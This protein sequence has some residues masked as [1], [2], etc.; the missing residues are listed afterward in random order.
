MATMAF[1]MIVSEFLLAQD[2]LTGGGA[3]IAVP[4]FNPPFDTPNGLFWLV[5]LIATVVTWLTWNVS[6]LMWGRATIALRDSEVAAAAVGVPVFSIKLIVY[7]FS[8]VTAA[9]GGSLFGS[10]Q[11]YVTP[12]T[13]H[14][15]LGLFFFICIVIG[16]RGAIIGPL[17]GHRR[18]D[19]APRGGGAARQAR[20]VLLRRPAPAGGAARARRHRQPVHDAAREDPA[21]ATG[22]ACRGPGPRAAGL[23][24]QEHTRAMNQNP[25]HPTRRRD[26]RFAGR[27]RP[28][29]PGSDPSRQRRVAASSSPR[30]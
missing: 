30:T 25:D 4:G 15:E 1:S 21:E 27:S 8:G 6:R 18:P 5:L 17:L 28:L 10:L 26:R 9:I 7:T 13:F 22:E 19:G 24:D 2:S 3:G 14:F 16:G 20:P 12:E 11:S 23:R 29:P